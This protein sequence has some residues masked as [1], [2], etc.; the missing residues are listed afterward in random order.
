MCM[1][2]EWR[3]TLFF[4]DE[5]NIEVELLLTVVSCL[6]ALA[7]GSSACVRLF[8]DLVEITKGVEDLRNV[9]E[10]IEHSQDQER[11]R[12]TQRQIGTSF[13]LAC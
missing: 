6:P 9:F 3:Y 1:P 10:K 13:L 12:L 5:Y 11:M 7:R 8:A 2:S 4:Q